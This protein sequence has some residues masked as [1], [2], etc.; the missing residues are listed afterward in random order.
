SNGRVVAVQSSDNNALLGLTTGAVSGATKINV[1]AGQDTTVDVTGALPAGLT[2]N[3]QRD[4]IVK[5]A[6]VN[7]DAVQA[8]RDI[9]LTTTAGDLAN[10][11]ALT[12]ARNITVVTPGSL[13]LGD[14]SATGG[15]IALTGRSVAAGALTAG[16]D[17]TLKATG[18]GVQLV[19]FKTGR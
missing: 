9:T 16:Q 7:F 19:S 5:A 13:Q 2:V 18:G 4:A 12:A 1:Q 10:T 17:L 11:H 3:A 6:S 8:G 15:S 14:I